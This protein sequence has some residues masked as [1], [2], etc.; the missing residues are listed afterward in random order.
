MEER[1]DEKEQFESC[2]KMAEYSH[3]QF[4]GR[5][6][7]EWKITL[8]FWVAMLT[9]LHK[10]W[11]GAVPRVCLGWWVGAWFLFSWLWLRGIYVANR[12]D[13]IREK[14]F[15]ELAAYKITGNLP[16]KIECKCRCL[17]RL[18]QWTWFEFCF[19]FLTN[20]SAQFQ[21]AVTAA[22]MY[23]AYWVTNHH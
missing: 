18:Q 19:G 14:Q 7:Y 13:K 22:I 23:V 4:D 17:N 6:Q 12:N 9:I 8:A 15:Y 1:V 21:M 10:D 5:R 2:L 16:R 11:I 20:W 3:R